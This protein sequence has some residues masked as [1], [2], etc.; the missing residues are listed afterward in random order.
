MDILSKTRSAK[1]LCAITFH[2]DAS[3][4]ALLADVLRSLAEF[5]I[6]ALDVVIA[7]NTT[8]EDQCRT[9]ERLCEGALPGAVISIRS[10]TG[11]AN[12]WELT[13]RHKRLIADHFLTSRHDDYTHFIYLEGDIRLSFVNFCYF[14]ESRETLRGFGLIP[15]F[16]RV[17]YSLLLNRLTCSDSFWPIYVPVQPKV[18]VENDVFLNQSL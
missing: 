11:L 14:I 6:R 7:T 13:W 4:L 9:L 12:P 16:V 15:A 8:V 1:V 18:I 5:P 3:R 17:E 2:Y 10:E